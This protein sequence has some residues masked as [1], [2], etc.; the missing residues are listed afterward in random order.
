MERTLLPLLLIAAGAACD[1]T[2]PDPVVLAFEEQS[3]RLSEFGRHLRSLEREGPLDRSV[4]R[5]VFESFVEERV[6]VLEARRRNLLASGSDSSQ[7]REAVQ[8]LLAAA[9]P[10]PQVSE[11][12][13]ASY[14]LE[15]Q[16]DFTVP[17]TVTLHQ[18]LVPTE[19]ES[20]DVRRRL[21]KDPRSFEALARSRSRGPEAS[22]G[23]LMGTFARGQLPPELEAAAF[24]LPAG[25]HSEPVKTA[26]GYHVLRVDGRQPGR[27]RA[28][29]ECRD[30]LRAE[31][32]RRKGERAVRG[33]V[34]G[35]LARAKVNH[36]AVEAADI[37][38]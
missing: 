20:R 9:A 3:V 34:Q 16:A 6:L 10:V 35:L 22:T 13:L 28:F 26:F 17:E 14:Y 21:Q 12:E 7:E 8:Q 37:P 27:A 15:H 2:R 31:L 23:G 25:A 4:R 30:E 36:E 11:E 19:N 1:R 29:E 38:N 24:A 18:I 5:A 32:E 33:F